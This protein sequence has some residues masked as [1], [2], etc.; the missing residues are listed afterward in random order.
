MAKGGAIAICVFSCSIVT[1]V[2]ALVIAFDVAVLVVGM[3][4]G[5]LWARNVRWYAW[6]RRDLILSSGGCMESAHSEAM[7]AGCP[8]SF[9]G[10]TTV[11]HN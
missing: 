10:C 6:D 8:A 1:L 2:I 9:E 4:E 7:R 3:E 5:A 11:I